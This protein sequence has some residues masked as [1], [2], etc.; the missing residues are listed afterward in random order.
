MTDQLFITLNDGA[1]IP[2][3]GLGVWQTPNDEAPPAVK[4][5]LDAGYRHVDT[6]AVYENEEGV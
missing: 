1:R 2:Q 5:A 4:A 3:V 6:A